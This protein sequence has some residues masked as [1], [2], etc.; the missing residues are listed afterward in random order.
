MPCE[1]A[2][3]SIQAFVRSVQA[4]LRGVPLIAFL[5]GVLVSWRSW[6][7]ERSVLTLAF[8]RSV[9]GGQIKIYSDM[10]VIVLRHSTSQFVVIRCN[11]S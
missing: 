10:Q 1:N 9:P 5:R 3:R 4:F 7:S 11:T 8:L 6:R 2:R